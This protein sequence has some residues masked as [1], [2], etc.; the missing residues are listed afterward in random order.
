MKKHAYGIAALV[1]GIIALGLAVIPGI[2]L[3]RPLPFAS[4]NPT[5]PPPVPEQAGGVT[6]QYKSFSVRLGGG[7][8]DEDKA[9]QEEHQR[10]QDLA[11]AAHQ[12]RIM[13]RDRFLKWFTISA[14]SC[15][16]VGLLLGPISWARERQPAVSGAAMGI[17]C[18]AIIWQYVVIGIVIGVA[19]AFMLMVISLFAS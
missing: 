15:S 3:D 17:C 7:K 13:D 12:Q 1:L 9:I 18:L 14:V 19:I 5:P 16:L 4:E 6:F 11:A 10:R 8:R 2:A